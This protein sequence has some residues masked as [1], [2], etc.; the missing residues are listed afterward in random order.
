ML[1]PKLYL[2]PVTEAALNDTWRQA[3]GSEKT[4]LTTL[5]HMMLGGISASPPMG[6]RPISESHSRW[7]SAAAGG[8]SLNSPCGVR[9]AWGA[10]HAHTADPNTLLTP[11]REQGR[12]NINLSQ[13][14]L[15]PQWTKCKRKNIIAFIDHVHKRKMFWGNTANQK[16]K[17][18]FNISIWNF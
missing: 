18:N 16:E 15:A 14:M 5:W 11:A 12:P 10:A 13:L 7:T 17:L 9:A 4:S 8:M 3:H 1:G 2:G 6:S